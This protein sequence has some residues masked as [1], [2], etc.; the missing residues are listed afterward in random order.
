MSDSMRP[1]GRQPM[2]LPCP[3]DSPGKNTGVGCH[4]FLQC[5]KVKSESEDTQSCPTLSDP[6]DYS[7]PGSSVH[8]IFQARVLEWAAIA[9]SMGQ[10][11]KMQNSCLGVWSSLWPQTVD[12]D[13][14]IS[15]SPSRDGPIWSE[16]QGVDRELD[17]ECQPVVI[18][19]I[20]FSRGLMSWG[21]EIPTVRAGMKRRLENQRLRGDSQMKG[22]C[23]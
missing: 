5:M 16:S 22:R 6:M 9:F 12:F 23:C 19:V 2:R 15:S 21:K 1:H 7:L 11:G 20:F 18:S 3:W 14:E 10:R 4:F 17:Q 13:A 8:G